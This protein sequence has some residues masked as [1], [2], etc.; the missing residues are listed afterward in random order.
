MARLA[1]W[2]TDLPKVYLAAAGLIVLGLALMVPRGL[3]MLDFVQEARFAAA[4]NFQAGHPSP[5]L[6]RPWMTLRYV[7][8]AYA[9]PQ[10]YLFD[11]LGIQPR[12]ETSLLSISRLNQMQRL[13]QVDG[14]PALLGQVRAAILQ[15]QAAPV[16]TGL[17]ERQ[18]EDWMTIQYLAN[19]TGLSPELFFQELGVPADG[20]AYQPVGFLSDVLDY[21]GGPPALAQALQRIVDAHTGPP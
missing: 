1:R 2:L 17:L 3:R 12:K 8:A 15:Y 9:V 6:L 21:P 18:V 13:G 19:S 4:H 10:A 11:A 7:A 14:Q 5:D 16:V 20:H